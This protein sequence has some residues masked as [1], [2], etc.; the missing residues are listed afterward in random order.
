M[1]SVKHHS[2]A[3]SLL[4]VQSPVAI[5]LHYEHTS[6]IYLLLI[7]CLSPSLVF[8]LSLSCPLIQAQKCGLPVLKEK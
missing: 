5:L 3:I 1:H 7:V 4:S 8:L 2:E 6:P